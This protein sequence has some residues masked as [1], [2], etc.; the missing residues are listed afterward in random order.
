M[1]VSIEWSVNQMASDETYLFQWSSLL[2]R[3]HQML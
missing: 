1:T 3:S 2:G